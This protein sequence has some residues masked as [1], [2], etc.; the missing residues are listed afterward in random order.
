VP[1]PSLATN[2]PWRMR[3]PR[4]TRRPA[5]ATL[6]RRG[7]R[8]KRRARLPLHLKRDPSRSGDDSRA[9]RPS[10]LAPKPSNEKL[11]QRAERGINAFP[12]LE[13]PYQGIDVPTS[14]QDSSQA[15]GEAVRFAVSCSLAGQNPGPSI[16][17]GMASGSIGGLLGAPDPPFLSFVSQPEESEVPHRLAQWPPSAD[18]L[19]PVVARAPAAPEALLAWQLGQ[20]EL[21]ILPVYELDEPDGSPG[22]TPVACCGFGESLLPWVSP[23]PSALFVGNPSVWQS[24]ASL[25]PAS[26]RSRCHI[27]LLPPPCGT[28]RDQ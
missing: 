9:A 23:K 28:K 26:G 25:N 4:P 13:T 19:Q 1:Y 15:P 24:L 8:P 14:H 12:K 17:L 22:S 7:A 21:E 3:S 6:K 16:P 5:S 18:Q 2:M 27:L 11:D 10:S 20:Y